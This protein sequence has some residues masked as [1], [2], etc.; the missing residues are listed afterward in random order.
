MS[1][2]GRDRPSP[3]AGAIPSKLVFT[4]GLR[5]TRVIRLVLE[6][7]I[8]TGKH[9]WMPGPLQRG[10]CRSNPYFSNWASRCTAITFD[11][12]GV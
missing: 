7:T 10:A 2:T 8:E 6:L 1:S 5:P 4:S 9:R 3:A 12:I 11:V